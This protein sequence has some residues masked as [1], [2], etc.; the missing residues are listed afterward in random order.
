V[1]WHLTIMSHGVVLF[2]ASTRSR[3]EMEDLAAEA[4]RLRPDIEIVIRPDLGMSANCRPVRRRTFEQNGNA[5]RRTRLVRTRARTGRRQTR[6][7]LHVLGRS[8]HLRRPRPAPNVG[9]GNKACKGFMTCVKHGGR[10][11]A[12]LSLHLGRPTLLEPG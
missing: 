5:R 9:C 6:R 7:S 3:R 1:G 8:T 2:T 4:R 10:E 11:A 12:A